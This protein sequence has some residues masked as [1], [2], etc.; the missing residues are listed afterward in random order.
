MKTGNILYNIILS[1]YPF[2]TIVAF[3]H[4]FNATVVQNGQLKVSLSLVLNI[5]LELPRS[6]STVIVLKQNQYLSKYCLATS[7]DPLYGDKQFSYT[8]DTI[9]FQEKLY[10]RAHNSYICFYFLLILK[11]QIDHHM[12]ATLLSQTVKPKC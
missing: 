4:F 9:R 3:T 1:C 6:S 2:C 8:E 5:V 11:H 7:P 12:E 10:M